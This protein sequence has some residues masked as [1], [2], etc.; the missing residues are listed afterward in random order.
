MKGPTGEINQY[1]VNAR[2]HVLC[3]IGTQASWEDDLLIQLAAVCA[4]GSKAI[5][6]KDLQSFVS[7]LPMAVQDIISFKTRDQLPKTQAVLMHGSTEEILKFSQF[8]SQR[9][10]PLA[11]LIGLQPG[12]LDL[13]LSR[14]VQERSIS[15]NTTAAGGNASLM[16]SVS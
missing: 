3:S 5:V 2:P 9:E 10:G 1:F 14:L 13:P 16:S 8:L 11:S 12:T 15:V 7:T 4:I 6:L